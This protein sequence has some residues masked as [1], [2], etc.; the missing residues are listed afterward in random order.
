MLGL[1]H[2]L[3]GAFIS[4]HSGGESRWLDVLLA[5]GAEPSHAAQ[6]LKSGSICAIDAEVFNRSA[7]Y[8]HAVETALSAIIH[9]KMCC[10]SKLPAWTLQ[11]LPFH[12]DLILSLTGD[13]VRQV[14]ELRSGSAGRQPS[15]VWAG[16]WAVLY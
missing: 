8:S 15:T 13:A 3:L 7:S 11:S 14:V 16:V 10:A 5:A 12:A 2:S 4:D 6:L 1:V 9:V